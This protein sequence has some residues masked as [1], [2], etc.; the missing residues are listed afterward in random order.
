MSAST[1]PTYR[2]RTPRPRVAHAVGTRT[3]R[4]GGSARRVPSRPT[5]PRPQP[6][7]TGA[8]DRQGAVASRA[9]RGQGEQPAIRIFADA[10]R[11]GPKLYQFSADDAGL[12]GRPSRDRES[13][14]LLSP[15]SDFFQ[16]LPQHPERTEPG[17]ADHDA[18][19]S[20]R[21][22]FLRWR[23]NRRSPRL[24]SSVS[25][26]PSRPAFEARLPRNQGVP[27][28]L[29]HPSPG[30]RRGPAA[31]GQ[32]R[33]AR[34]RRS[35]AAARPTSSAPPKRCTGGDCRCEMRPLLRSAGAAAASG[36]GQRLAPR[37]CLGRNA[38]RARCP[39]RAQA[40]R[41]P[42]SGILPDSWSATEPA[43]GRPWPGGRRPAAAAPRGA[44]ARL[45][46]RRRCRAWS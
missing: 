28:R 18:G 15:D 38:A 24:S 2:T 35:S 46:L 30:R 37:R 45:R 5:P 23:T 3:R 44:V 17:P 21:P 31:P 1:T 10:Y 25:R 16:L 9:L 11:D 32:A 4:P 43:A 19:A 27:M 12:C 41:L 22:P 34:P 40:P 29:A 14:L 26:L 36:R 33:T 8:A 39:R 13:R 7:G 42:L 6:S 20:G